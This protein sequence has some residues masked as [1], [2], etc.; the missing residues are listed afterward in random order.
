MR[1]KT[2]NEL[3]AVPAH[4]LLSPSDNNDILNFINFNN[5]GSS[6][7]TSSSA[8]KKIQFSTKTNPQNLFHSTND[9]ALKYNKIYDLYLS[10]SDVQ[11]SLSY[12]VSRQHNFMSSSAL[13]NNYSSQLDNNSVDK[14][15]SYN[16]N[17]NLIS[18]SYS[19]TST[20]ELINPSSSNSK[21][22]LNLE[23]HLNDTNVLNSYS[24]NSDEYSGKEFGT[25]INSSVDLTSNNKSLGGLSNDIQTFNNAI[26]SSYN[27]FDYSLFYKIFTNKSPN[28]QV[29]SADRNIRNLDTLNPLKMNYNLN[30]STSNIVSSS[31]VFPQSHIPSAALGTKFVNIDYDKFNSNGMNNSFMSAKEELAPNFV[32]SPY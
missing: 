20:N 23:S 8:F 14:I 15:I 30:T 22:S 10:D 2:Q 12:G 19:N 21:F 16:N 5:L 9:F 4:L 24:T 26:H 32:F 11:S 25:K 1:A 17:T 3:Q 28:Q 6:T 29:L 18:N 31:T 13:T 27:M 7:L